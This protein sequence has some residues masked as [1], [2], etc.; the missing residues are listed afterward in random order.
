MGHSF[1]ATPFGA[2]FSW[3]HHGTSSISGTRYNHAPFYPKTGPVDLMK[4]HWQTEG[5]DNDEYMQKYGLYER[6]IASED[7]VKAFIFGS[8][9]IY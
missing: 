6:S 5:I 2:N 8:K 1:L 9:R 7:D 3:G 4:Y